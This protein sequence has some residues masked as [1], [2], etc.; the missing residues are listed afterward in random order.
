[1]TPMSQP[2]LHNYF[3]DLPKKKKSSLPGSSDPN[4]ASM[5]K[6]VGQ[7]FKQVIKKCFPGCQHRTSTERNR[8]CCAVPNLWHLESLQRFISAVLK[9]LPISVVSG[10]FK[11]IL[12]RRCAQ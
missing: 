8:L 1:V 11:T 5:A 9:V 4:C 6:K 7:Y 12:H 2:K 10:F 3:C